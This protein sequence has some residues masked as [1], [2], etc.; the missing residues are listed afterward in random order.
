MWDLLNID[1][2]SVRGDCELFVT[3]R[4]LTQCLY[5]YKLQKNC[6]GAIHYQYA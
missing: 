2:R 6:N 1:N 3:Q 4:F 5:F